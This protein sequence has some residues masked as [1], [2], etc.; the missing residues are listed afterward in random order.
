[1]AKYTIKSNGP[2]LS[3]DGTWYP[4][5]SKVELTDDQALR[6]AIHLVEMDKGDT[7][8]VKEGSP[9]PMPVEPIVETGKKK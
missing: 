9:T 4:P 5:G 1:M 8:T 7:L 6:V 3:L 2:N